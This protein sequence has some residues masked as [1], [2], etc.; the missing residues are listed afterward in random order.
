M[1]LCR[2]AIWFV[3]R[4]QDS[5]VWNELRLFI[6]N[7]L[8]TNM[9]KYYTLPSHY[10]RIFSFLNLGQFTRN[11]FVTHSRFGGQSHSC[12]CGNGDVL[13]FFPS[14]FF[15]ALFFLVL[16]SSSSSSS[17][18]SINY[19]AWGQKDSESRKEKKNRDG[20]KWWHG[21]LFDPSRKVGRAS[22]LYLK[23]TRVYG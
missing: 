10:S 18:R 9:L 2:P 12:L 4:V 21:R 13:L 23:G 3:L 17:F 1:S 5:L 11:S 15:G 20:S 8:L 6:S 22:L 14:T 7:L 16:K 19:F